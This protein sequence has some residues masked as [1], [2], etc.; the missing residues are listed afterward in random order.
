M[1]LLLFLL[2]VFVTAQL[3]AELNKLVSYGFRKELT[4]IK[5]LQYVIGV[6]IALYTVVSLALCIYFSGAMKEESKDKCL[7]K[8]FYAR[9][10]VIPV[11]ILY[12]TVPI[13]AIIIMHVKNYKPQ[14]RAMVVKVTKA[15]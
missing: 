13:L 2:Y 11:E 8:L 12:E 3:R 6:T 14:E 7:E 1:L 10:T 4:L 9:A 15:P 5:I